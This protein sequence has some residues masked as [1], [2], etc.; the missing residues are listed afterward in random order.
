MPPD[1]NRRG[2][3]PAGF[4]AVA[5][6]C[7]AALLSFVLA[8]HCFPGGYN[9]AMRVLSALG[10]TE[11]RLVEWPWSH[12]LFMAKRPHGNNQPVLSFATFA[13]FAAKHQSRVGSFSVERGDA[14]YTIYIFYTAIICV[15]LRSGCFLAGGE[16]GA[17]SRQIRRAPARFHTGKVV[18]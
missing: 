14:F 5:I 8:M 9:P 4:A 10:R 1:S 2:W 3:M 16:T 7:T 13:F 17:A 15:G 12:Y 6:L 11:V 18:D